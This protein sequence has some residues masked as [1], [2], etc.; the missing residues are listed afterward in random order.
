MNMNLNLQSDSV[1]AV[2]NVQMQLTK[3]AWEVSVSQSNEK[4]MN[5]QA[6]YTNKI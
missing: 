6:L 1:Y 2:C 4:H 5:N 3:T